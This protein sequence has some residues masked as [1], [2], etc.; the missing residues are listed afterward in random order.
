MKSSNSENEADRPSEPEGDLVAAESE[1]ARGYIAN[2]ELARRLLEEFSAIDR[3][4][5]DSAPK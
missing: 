2:A 3:E 4:G 5:F 1:L